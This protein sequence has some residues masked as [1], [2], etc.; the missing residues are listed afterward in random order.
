MIVAVAYDCSCCMLERQMCVFRGH[1]FNSAQ[2]FPIF[3]LN[4]K[5]VSGIVGSQ[6]ELKS[7]KEKICCHNEIR[8]L[9][10]PAALTVYLGKLC[11]GS[12]NHGN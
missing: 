12:T 6:L 5:S 3:S 1:I 11:P 4:G 9:G 10:T 2:T 7:W 8:S